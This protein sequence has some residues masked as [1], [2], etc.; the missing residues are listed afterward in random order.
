[1]CGCVFHRNVCITLK[2]Q[3]LHSKLYFFTLVLWRVGSSGIPIFRS[4]GQGC[5]AVAWI[6]RKQFF[7]PRPHRRNQ[8][9]LF[10]LFPIFAVTTAVMCNRTFWVTNHVR[11]HLL[12]PS[13]PL[14]TSWVG[15]MGVPSRP[16]RRQL[17]ECQWESPTKASLAW[18]KGRGGGSHE[19]TCTWISPRP[20]PKK[21]KCTIYLP[22]FGV[23]I[24]KER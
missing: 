7:A 10:S 22:M 11:F 20:P 2:V 6:A 13:I 9:F 18:E 17:C 21:S 1:M 19:G 14:R 24:K 3:I 5:L 15:M 16:N 23:Q 12:E 8:A 4:G